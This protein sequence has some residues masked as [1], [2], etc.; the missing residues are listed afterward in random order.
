M[1]EGGLVLQAKDER[2]VEVLNRVLA[3]LLQI[4][5]AAPL[6]GV[7]ERQA[8]RLL[9]AYREEGPR[10]IV[11]GNRG[12]K[13]AHALG[14]ELRGQLLALAAGP[15]AGVN[16]THLAQLLTEREGIS[17]PRTTLS[18]LLREAGIRSPRPQKRRSKHRSRRERYPQEGMLLQ[19]DASH[20]PW[21]QER[22]PRFALLAVIDD[23]TGKVA[24]ARFH[25]T[26]DT[27]GY[28]LLLRDVCRKVGAPQA[29]YSDHHGTF[30]PTHGESLQEQLAG[31]RSPTQFGRAMAELGVQLIL[32]HS[33]QA[34]G[35]IE[36]LWGTLQNRLVSELRLAGAASIEEANAF[37]PAFLTRFNRT[38][39]VIPATPGRAYQPRRTAAELDTI[40]CLKHDRVV[41]K[42]NTVRLGEI[43]LQVLPGPHRI[44]YAK[45][46][47]TIHE[48][49]DARFSVYFQGRKL[50]TRLVPLRARLSPK[51][52]KH[53]RP[54]SASPPP[55]SVAIPPAKSRPTH[56]WRTYPTVSKS[57]VT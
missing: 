18:D 51:P 48:S 37:L 56:P 21:L 52:A 33:P 1:E 25:P 11:H 44:G 17:I 4:T 24:A 29:I 3:G 45:A 8:R 31:R 50:P 38:F 6:L 22:A 13:P 34:K 43:V 10:G 40:F 54:P 47:V 26:E 57:L 42:D 7:G 53:R 41:S 19:I 39:A 16:H 46:M 23:A 30:W 27:Q 32:A 9:A 49:F 12:R 55:L 2:R 14:E 36:R 15:Y 20:H 35:R 5:E 28:F